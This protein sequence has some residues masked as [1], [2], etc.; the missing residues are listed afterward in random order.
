M[1][2]NVLL[3]SSLQFFCSVL[4]LFIMNVMLPIFVYC[5]L[6]TNEL[7][8][9]TESNGRFSSDRLSQSI[10]L[11][12]SVCVC[13]DFS[14]TTRAIFTKFLWMF[15]VAVTR[16][17]SGIVAIRYVLPLLWMTSC[18]FYSGPYSDMNFA[19]KNRFCLNSLTAKAD[20]I[21]F[22]IIKGHNFD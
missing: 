3:S 14:A 12:T 7:D 5:W 17:S 16:S 6:A 15:P 4:F 11:T 22:S 20:R 10:V 1:W 21:L 13:E 2:L 8:D 9:C 18:F 19:M